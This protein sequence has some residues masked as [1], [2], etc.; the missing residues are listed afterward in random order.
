MCRENNNTLNRRSF[1]KKVRFALGGLAIIQTLI[2]ISEFLFPKRKEGKVASSDFLIVGKADEFQHNT[3]T[4]FRKN[5]FFLS[6]LSNGNFLALSIYCSHMGCIVIWDKD[7][8]QFNC[9]CHSSSFDVKGK[10]INPP[11]T[12]ALAVHPVTIENGFVKVNTSVLEKQS[13]SGPVQVTSSKIK[14]G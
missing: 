4:S 13:L 9:P 3:V 14:K 5:K 7:K 11:A 1:L 6:R 12:Q 8:N 10:V 2:I